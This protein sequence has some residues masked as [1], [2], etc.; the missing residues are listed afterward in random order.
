[1]VQK[2]KIIAKEFSSEREMYMWLNNE[3]GL[4]ELKEKYPPTKYKAD[5]N[6]NDKQVIVEEK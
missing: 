6:L 4:S 5:L 3:K 1:M 2:K